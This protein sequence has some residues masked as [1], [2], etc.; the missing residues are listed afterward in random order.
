MWGIRSSWELTLAFTSS[1]LDDL[2]GHD[3]LIHE[4]L[5]QVSQRH[6]AVHIS[7]S[8]SP[9]Q[10]LPSSLQTQRQAL[11]ISDG[12]KRQH[13]RTG[14][15]KLSRVHGSRIL[16]AKFYNWP[17]LSTSRTAARKQSPKIQEQWALLKAAPL[18]FAK[19]RELNQANMHYLK[20]ITIFQISSIYWTFS[21][22]IRWMPTELTLRPLVGRATGW[23]LLPSG[24][25]GLLAMWSSVKKLA[26]I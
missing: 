9:N 17:S 13:D 4:G 10:F 15:L 8:I 25:G 18:I 2:P 20:P 19:A 1:W 6:R 24:N 5:L 16:V 26:K 14:E 7:H 21:A 22:L 23:P 12:R 11:H 3:A